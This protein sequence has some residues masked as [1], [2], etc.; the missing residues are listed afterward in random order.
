MLDL[1]P[2]TIDIFPCS[3]NPHLTT[4]AHGK[5]YDLTEVLGCAYTYNPP[6]PLKHVNVYC[7]INKFQPS[8]HLQPYVYTFMFCIFANTTHKY[9]QYLLSIPGDFE[10]WSQSN[11]NTSGS[12]H[13]TLALTLTIS[14]P[15][16]IQVKKLM[17]HQREM[18][19]KW[20]TSHGRQGH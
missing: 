7:D 4:K 10:R 5:I 3:S 8:L 20:L 13:L 12:T 1:C 6:P 11:A 15:T 2:T 19:H 16:Y 9:L 14:P 18:Y 17:C